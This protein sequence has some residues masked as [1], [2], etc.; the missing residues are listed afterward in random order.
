MSSIYAKTKDGVP[1]AFEAWWDPKR[2]AAVFLLVQGGDLGM[3]DRDRMGEM[4]ADIWRG[5]LPDSLWTTLLIMTRNMPHPAPC[6]V[7][8]DPKAKDHVAVFRGTDGMAL[9]AMKI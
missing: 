4:I 7:E 6:T 9:Y 5:N 3:I 2:A 8:R 1:P